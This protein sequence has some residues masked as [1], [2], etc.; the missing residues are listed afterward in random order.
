LEGYL[1]FKYPSESLKYD[2]RV[3]LFFDDGSVV[4]PLVQRITN[5]FSHLGEFIDRG[6]VPVDGPEI[7]TLAKFVLERLKTSDG[8]QYLHF[9]ESVGVSDP[10]A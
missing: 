8:T 10:I 9:L 6:S 7:S 2:D 5:E 1:F 4:E 3:R